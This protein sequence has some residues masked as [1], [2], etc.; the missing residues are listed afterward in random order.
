MSEYVKPNKQKIL[1]DT[2]NDHELLMAI[3]DI[4]KT[5]DELQHPDYWIADTGASM[6]STPMIWDYL[7][8]ERLT[9]Q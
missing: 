5:M 3:A 8:V 7:I 6:R 4:P 9:V 2:S 1:T